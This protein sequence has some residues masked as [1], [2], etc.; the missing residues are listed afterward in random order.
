MRIHFES[1]RCA[2]CIS[3]VAAAISSALAGALQTLLYWYVTRL[4][5]QTPG[6]VTGIIHSR[7]KRKAS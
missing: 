3:A 2:F 6:S 4:E 7:K 5:R 1:S